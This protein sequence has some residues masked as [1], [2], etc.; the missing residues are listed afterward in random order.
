MKTEKELIELSIKHGA[1]KAYILDADQIPFD[2]NLRSYCEMNA[3]G[4][5]GKNYTCPPAVGD[6]D[7][8]IEEAKSYRKAL[9]YQTITA[10]EDSFDIEGMQEA[11]RIH[12]EVSDKIH[13]DITPNLYKYLEL[14]AGGCKV[15]PQCAIRV[16][17]PCRFPEKK[18]SSLEAY[19]IDVSGLSEKCDMNYI[20]G[21]NTVT[22]FGAF[23][24]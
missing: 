24:I 17:E 15:C 11:E 9:V 6:V 13:A 18:R 5:Y 2:K 22:H 1:K 19:C 20:N 4:E 10:L 12:E 23:L 16:Q 8:L 14:R 21:K 7:D 3:C